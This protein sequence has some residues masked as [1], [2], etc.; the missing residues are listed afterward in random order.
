MGITIGMKESQEGAHGGNCVIIQLMHTFLSGSIA[1]GVGKEPRISGARTN[2]EAV[3]R[4]SLRDADMN[5]IVT[6]RLL[7][8]IAFLSPGKI[9]TSFSFRAMAARFSSSDY[10]T[11]DPKL[12]W[13]SPLDSKETFE[14]KMAELRL[15]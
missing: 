1:R 3:I 6:Y 15:L 14:T 8:N 9:F 12:V 5:F 2:G 10:F 13:N 11:T 4:I 7:H